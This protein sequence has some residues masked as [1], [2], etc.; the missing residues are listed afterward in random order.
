M[1]SPARPSPMSKWNFL[2]VVIF[3][4]ISPTQTFHPQTRFGGIIGNRFGN[5]NFL[6][7]SYALDKFQTKSIVLYTT[8]AIINPSDEIKGEVFDSDFA[9][10]FSKPLP[11]WYREE[12]KKK[13]IFMKEVQENRERILREFRAKYEVSEADKAKQIKDKWERAEA[14]MLEKE[15]KKNWIA[16][17]FGSATTSQKKEKV[18]KDRGTLTREKWEKFRRAEAGIDDEEETDPD[19]FYL[20]GFFEVFP[21]LK[22]KWPDWTRAKNGQPLKC[23]KDSD[24]LFPQ[25]CC[26][27]P[28]FPGES[29]C[30][31]GWG[32][33]AMVPQ[34]CPQEINTRSG[35][36]SNNGGGGPTKKDDQ[37]WRPV[38]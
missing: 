9:D 31:T 2:T 23:K 12:L 21:E 11:D 33:R 18:E 5:N 36:G 37:S 20:P 6:K 26:Q 27:H 25:A 32:R 15:N 24:C 8:S 14:E 29:F 34:Y 16:N 19:D 22:L 3:N 1:E 4:L 7:E 13:E 17:L 30:C 28:I 35:D 10:A 38:D